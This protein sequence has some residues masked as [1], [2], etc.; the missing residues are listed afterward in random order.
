MIN[1]NEIKIRDKIRLLL[2]IRVFD[3]LNPHKFAFKPYLALFF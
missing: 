3:S 1:K 2:I